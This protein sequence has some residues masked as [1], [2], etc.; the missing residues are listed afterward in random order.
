MKVSLGPLPPPEILQKYNQVEPGLAERI[1]SMVEKQS[2]HRRSLEKKVVF[3]GERRAL[4][5]QIMAFVIALVGIAYPS[6]EHMSGFYSPLGTQS[7]N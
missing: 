1:V 3:S 2:E 4:L 6:G 5:G 7:Q